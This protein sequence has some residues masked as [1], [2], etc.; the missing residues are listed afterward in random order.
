[1][2]SG[3]RHYCI[4]TVRLVF[5]DVDFPGGLPGSPLVVV[6][7]VVRLTSVRCG[8]V[9]GVLSRGSVGSSWLGVGSTAMM[10]EFELEL[11]F[12]FVSVSA[13]DVF[14]L[15]F[16]IASKVGSGVGAISKVGSGV[17]DGSTAAAA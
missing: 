10:S 2:S 16:V 12:E 4:M 8:L 6:D 13:I 17:G 3:F 14:E 7:V 5:L 11:V 9:F 1:M 15:A